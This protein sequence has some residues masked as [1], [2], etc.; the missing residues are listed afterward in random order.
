ME[1]RKAISAHIKDP[2][3]IAD[4]L[5]KGVVAGGRQIY[6]T[7]CVSCH[8]YDGRGDGSRFP[9]LDSSEWVNG[10]KKRLIGILLYGM[11]QPVTINGKVFNNLMP[12]HDFLSDDQMASVLT[13]IRQN[14]NNKS[15]AVT[16]EEVGKE[17]NNAAA[18]K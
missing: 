18:K 14:F 2:D 1:K 11:E 9:P 6:N 4:N 10:D 17:R 16:S 5:Q 12:K 7:Y 3:E 8:Q 15:S 13:Y